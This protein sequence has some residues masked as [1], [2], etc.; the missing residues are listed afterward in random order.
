M[1]MFPTNILLATDGSDNSLPALRAAAELSARTESG[2]QIVYV[3]KDI[4]TPA[5]YNDPSAK[6][7]EAVKKARALIE[8]QIRRIEADGGTVAS[9]HVVPG[10][11]PAKEIVNFTRG[12]EIGL[13]VV[14]SR[15]LGRLR[16]ALG[17]SVSAA[18]VRD[19]YCPVFVVHGQE[20]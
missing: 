4:S 2:I 14:G 10:K 5:A 20:A 3:G 11:N 8:E 9:S 13:A 1:G 16:Y 17:G 6:D 7:T 15:G 12:D 18:V 19:A